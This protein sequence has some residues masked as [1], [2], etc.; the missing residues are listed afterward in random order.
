MPF[1]P[2]C[3]QSGYTTFA[4]GVAVGGAYA[5]PAPGHTTAMTSSYDKRLHVYALGTRLQRPALPQK[6]ACVCLWALYLRHSND[7]GMPLAWRN[8]LLV[9]W[10]NP[11]CSVLCRAILGLSL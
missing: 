7:Q 4:L 1:F 8:P 10:R 6:A 5:L 3:W 2:T 9:A 11:A